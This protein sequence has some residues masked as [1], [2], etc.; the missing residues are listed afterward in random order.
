MIANYPPKITAGKIFELSFTTFGR[1]SISIYNK[2]FY[3]RQNRNNFF[4]AYSDVMSQLVKK[5][6]ENKKKTKIAGPKIVGR[7][8]ELNPSSSGMN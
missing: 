6:R 1:V 5:K 4:F 2:Y 8:S 7:I 3:K